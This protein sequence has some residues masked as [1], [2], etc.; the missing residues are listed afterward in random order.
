MVDEISEFALSAPVP[1]VRMIGV[2]GPS[3]AGK[4]TL[5]LLLASRLDAP[6]IQ[7]DDFVSWNNFSGWWDRFEDQVLRPL[8]SGHDATYQQRDWNGDEFGDGLAGW[9]TVK[10]S[11]VVVIEGVTCS[12]AAVS[13]DLACRVWMET[14]ALER[15]RRGLER[16][17]DSHRDLWDRW[18]IE[19]DT[20]FE[21]DNT[22]TRADFIVPGNT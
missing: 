8:L 3:G 6:L 19:E 22:R 18:M 9:R 16:D 1:G 17:G 5:A 7:I 14:P 2:D 10:W 20:F 12:R 11:P 21:R 4:S 13:N 15:L